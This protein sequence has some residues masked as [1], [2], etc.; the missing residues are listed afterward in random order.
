MTTALE[1]FLRKLSKKDHQKIMEV[2]T[3]MQTGDLQSLDIKPLKGHPNIARLRVGRYRILFRGMI[4]REI[5][6]I[7]I[8]KRDEKTYNL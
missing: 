2:V 6:I 7:K 3:Q 5:R 4:S 8:T 1:K